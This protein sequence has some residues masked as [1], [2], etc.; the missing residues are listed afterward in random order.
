[1][2]QD[3]NQ[4]FLCTTCYSSLTKCEWHSKL[5]VFNNL[6]LDKTPPELAALNDMECVFIQK[7]K[8]FQVIYRLGMVGS[9]LPTS[10]HLRVQKGVIVH[11]PL[12][13]SE[14]LRIL[15]DASSMPNDANIFI[16]L[17]GVPTKNRIVW[18]SLINVD[19]VKAAFEWLRR[20]NP[21]YS[22]VS[23][24][25]IPLQF[26]SLDDS[27]LENSTVE[28]CQQL[29]NRAMIRRL[30]DEEQ[31]NIVESYS[32]QPLIDLNPPGG[33]LDLYQMERVVADH[34]NSREVKLDLWC[35]PH[36]FPFGCGGE[37]DI[38]MAAFVT[39]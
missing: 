23:A 34:I 8:C 29:V 7:A 36:L 19:K 10:D 22:S 25:W 18:Q 38:A 9:K 33:D 14:T 12:P 35:F 39:F 27:K 24:D 20:N 13:I 3:A 32:V 28:A 31:Q 37:G 30:D 4:V 15:P 5:S 26:D 16:L 1:M 21:E 17:Y 2:E 6:E 11:Y